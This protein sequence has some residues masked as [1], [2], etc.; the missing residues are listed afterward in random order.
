MVY[1]ALLRGINVGGKNILKMA[2]L[3]RVLKEEAGL[4]RVQTYIQSG[5]VLFESS[6]EKSVLRKR[7]EQVIESAFGMSVSVIVRT[8]S[9][10]RSIADRCPFTEEELTKAAESSVGESLYVSILQ[11]ELPG[12]QVEKLHSADFGEDK[13]VILGKEIYLLYSN[14]SLN[15]KLSGRLDKLG[16]PATVRNFKTLNKLIDL[17]AEME[18]NIP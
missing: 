10:L 5:N 15:S 7:I 18:Q 4:A 11:E 17:A 14:S 16:V 9:E 13:Y 2:E 6:E 1:I 8:A 3:R 12:E